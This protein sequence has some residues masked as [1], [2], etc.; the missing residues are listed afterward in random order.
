M[1][2]SLDTNVFIE[3]IRGRNRLVRRRFAEASAA[4]EPLVA[5]LIVAHELYYGAEVHPDPFAQLR[6]AHLI[7]AQVGVTPFDARD[8]GM[9]AKVRAR[10]KARGLAIGPYDALIAGQ[11]LA[12]RW[13]VVTAN[14]R[15]FS[16]IDGL[17]VID[18]TAAG[19]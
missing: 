19:D 16:R 4:P 5:S 14:V 17:K 7:L 8:M 9:A 18:W 1:S 3:L 2:L 11:A 12:R 10:L 15:E 13:T 6:N